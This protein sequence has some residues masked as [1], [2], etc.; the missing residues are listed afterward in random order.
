MS[1]ETALK[2]VQT[3][4]AAV[5]TAVASATVAAVAAASSVTENSL[6]QIYQSL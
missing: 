4:A 1:V 5:G 3:V 6:N 2:A